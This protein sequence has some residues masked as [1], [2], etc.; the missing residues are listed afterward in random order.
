[1]TS[2]RP[3]TPWAAGR[4]GQTGP[5][6]QHHPNRR[7]AAPAAGYTNTVRIGYAR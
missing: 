2:P 1:M 7:T 4:P 6:A 3:A 5:R